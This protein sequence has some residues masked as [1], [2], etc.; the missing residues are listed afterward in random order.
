MLKSPNTASIF[1]KSKEYRELVNIKSFENEKQS[2]KRHFNPIALIGHARLVTD[3]T[4]SIHDNNQPVISEGIVGI[5]NGIIVNSG[6]LWQLYPDML[7]KYDVDSEVIF[8]LIRREMKKSGSLV[9]AV[10]RTFKLI[11]GQA[12][13]AAFFRDINSLLLY[14][15][16]GS[17]YVAINET[18]KILIFASEFYILNQLLKKGDFKK[19]FGGIK[20][21]KV[22]P[23]TGLVVDLSSNKIEWFT[24]NANSLLNLTEC[25][26]QIVDIRPNKSVKDQSNLNREVTSTFF[27]PSDFYTEFDRFDYAISNLKRCN[28]CLLS[29]TMP[30]ITFDSN[31]IC[32]YCKDYK[33]IEL[34][35]QYELEANING[36]SKITGET[37]C[38][39]CISGGRDSSYLLHYI[40]T[41][42]KLNTTAFTYDWGMVTDLARRN[43]SRLCGKLGVEHILLSADISKKRKYIRKNVTAWLKRPDLGIIPLFMAGDKQLWYYIY[44]IKKQ[45]GVDIIFFGQN[46]LERVEFKSGFAGVPPYHNEG[47]EKYLLSVFDQLRLAYYYGKSFLLNPVFINTSIF[48]TIWAFASYYI[49]PM[50]YINLYKYVKWDEET[51]RS[52]IIDEYD[53]EVADDTTSTWRIGDGTASFY[54]YIYYTL[55]GFTEN[56]GLRSNQIREGVITREKALSKVKQE[57]QPRWESIKWYCNTIGIDFEDTV[58]RINEIPK[59]YTL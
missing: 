55:A 18:D 10:Q 35:P 14:T 41:E 40:K 5:H 7:R 12:S 37:D 34:K 15:N 27:V 13:I 36:I 22:M 26:R 53:W 4:Q 16:H 1:I 21:Q 2:E 57:N 33:N 28:K 51:I 11:Y 31:D 25:D 29:E 44:K 48:D 20:I 6:E 45:I 56:D 52:T 47:K 42:L 39:V 3:G 46:P 50:K 38:L 23:G 19:Q 24:E 8:S 17:L 43:I 49:V 30:F 9:Q 59:L 54:N 32:N 58:R